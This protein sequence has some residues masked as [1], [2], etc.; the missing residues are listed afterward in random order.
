M[1]FTLQNIPTFCRMLECSVTLHNQ[2]MFMHMCKHIHSLCFNHKRTEP[3]FFLVNQKIPNKIALSGKK[4]KK[5]KS[6]AFPSRAPKKFFI[7]LSPP[8]FSFSSYRSGCYF[9]FYFYFFQKQQQPRPGLHPL[10]PPTPPPC[11][12]LWW[13]EK[14]SSLARPGGRVCRS[15]P[16]TSPIRVEKQRVAPPAEECFYLP[17][18]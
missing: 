16:T 13:S 3:S 1:K 8:F 6:P 14:E 7:S 18:G 4:G 2:H 10:W 15:L 5:E 12:P 11:R 17:P 9:S